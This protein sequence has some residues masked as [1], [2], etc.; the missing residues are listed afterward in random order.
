MCSIWSIWDLSA[1]FGLYVS[2]FDCLCKPYALTWVTIVS[3]HLHKPLNAHLPGSCC[4][5]TPSDS[6]YLGQKYDPTNTNMECINKGPWHFGL[7]AEACENGGGKYSRSPSLRLQECIAERPSVG[8]THGYSRA[9]EDWV[10]WGN[11]IYLHCDF[12]VLIIKVLH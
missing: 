5:D 1:S 8:D 3:L 4:L 7:T 11:H 12:E 9:F 6:Q 10:R 2:S